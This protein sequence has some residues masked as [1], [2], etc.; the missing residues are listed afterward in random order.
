MTEHR[1]GFKKIHQPVRNIG[2]DSTADNQRARHA[3]ASCTEAPQAR[4]TV[5]VVGHPLPRTLPHHEI[6]QAPMI[7]VCHPAH[8]VAEESSA[9][10]KALEVGGNPFKN[11]LDAPQAAPLDHMPQLRQ[12]L[13]KCD[14][15]S[16]VELVPTKGLDQ[17]EQAVLQG[18][19]VHE[20][21][22]DAFLV[23]KILEVPDGLPHAQEHDALPVHVDVRK[24][25][26]LVNSRHD[27]ILHD[28]F[29]RGA[30]APA[31]LE[32]QQHT[33]VMEE[34]I[35]HRRG[36]RQLVDLEHANLLLRIDACLQQLHEHFI[37]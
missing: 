30:V 6:P 22:P 8:Q 15:R 26:K 29:V 20:Y 36:D 21:I 28:V 18:R 10:G 34:L 2:W 32:R 13:V 4:H 3:V 24:A 23:G 7:H 16:N 27:V 1:E 35:M 25:D 14:T 37:P 33:K 12:S 9:V 19:H 11:T 17:F 5:H 31:A